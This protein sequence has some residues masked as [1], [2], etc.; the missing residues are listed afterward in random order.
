MLQH[1]AVAAPQINLSEAFLLRLA[2]ARHKGLFPRKVQILCGL[3]AK[4]AGER[5]PAS[6]KFCVRVG[7]FLVAGFANGFFFAFFCIS[8]QRRL[9]M[10][11]FARG[12]AEKALARP[13]SGDPPFVPEQGQQTMVAKTCTPSARIGDPQLFS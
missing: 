3:R 5:H 6:I 7:D 13:N 4:R 8:A 9:V 1:R 11:L 2:E 10:R 12:T